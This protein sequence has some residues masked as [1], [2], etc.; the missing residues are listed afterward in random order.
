M[1][2]LYLYDWFKIIF[3]SLLSFCYHSFFA[4]G[5]KYQILFSGL[6]SHHQ[7]DVG[8]LPDVVRGYGSS[9]GRLLLQP[10]RPTRLRPVLFAP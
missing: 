3:P 7:F 9:S 6:R 2:L 4:T 8:N 10:N 5:I 1:K